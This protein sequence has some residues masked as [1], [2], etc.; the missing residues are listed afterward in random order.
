MSGNFGYEY[1]YSAG[2]PESA[3]SAGA[4]D[5]GATVRPSPDAGGD[6]R[7]AASGKIEKGLKRILLIAAVA[8]AAHLLWFFVITPLIPFSRLEVRGFDGFEGAT[9]LAVAGIGENA[10]FFSL[11]VAQA[12]A[13]LAA[14]PL[15]ESA[16][17]IKHFPNRLSI[18]LEPR[19]AVAVSLAEAGGR[20]TPVFI[21][22]HGVVM[23]TGA[24]PAGSF[25]VPVLSG[26]VFHNPQAGMEM[27]RAFLPLLEDIS[28]ILDNSPELLAAISEIRLNRTAGDDFDLILF[29]VH[30]SIRVRVERQLS[31]STL[32]YVLLMLD[33][34]ETRFPRPQ[35][36]DF[37]SGV[38]TYRL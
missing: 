9:V 36:I 16:R 37:R 24:A 22:R 7:P 18:F 28:R 15:V 25:T 31:E 4:A 35:E 23:R 11:N 30:S 10:S 17:V 26:I 8:L 32:R 38:G 1:W 34:F 14:Y 2:R 6:S 12:E 29:P 33:V 5:A 20:P 3:A 13:R 19:R 27:P 21:D